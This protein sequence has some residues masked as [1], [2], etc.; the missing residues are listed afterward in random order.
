MCG[1]CGI[2]GWAGETGRADGRTRYAAS[3][4][5]PSPLPDTTLTFAR[6]RHPHSQPQGFNYITFARSGTDWDSTTIKA[7]RVGQ[8]SDS[9]RAYYY[10]LTSL[11]VQTSGGCSNPKGHLIAA[12]CADR[13]RMG[14]NW[15]RLDDGWQGRGQSGFP[16]F[17]NVDSDGYEA[18]AAVGQVDYG[19]TAVPSWTT[20]LQRTEGNGPGTI[21]ITIPL[22]EVSKEGSTTA[23]A[24]FE[25]ATVCQPCAVGTAQPLAST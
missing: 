11:S 20:N 10:L 19:G 23:N 24:D 12:A 8:I 15:P 3:T 5:L 6:C 9:Y 25:T 18:S 4:T 7:M 22:S 21:K 2:A 14:A 16:A 13:C 17:R 1:A